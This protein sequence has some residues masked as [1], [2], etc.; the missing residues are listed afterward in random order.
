M[1][2]SNPEKKAVEL[3]SKLGFSGL[4]R[5]GVIY[6]HVMEDPNLSMMAKGIY[7]VISSLQPLNCPGV[8]SLKMFS[9]LTNVGPG[10]FLKYRQELINAGYLTLEFEPP[11][12]NGPRVYI[13][14]NH[15]NS[16]TGSCTDDNGSNSLADMPS[17][18]HGGISCITMVRSDMNLREKAVYAYI[19]SL[20]GKT[21]P[22]PKAVAVVMNKHYC[23]IYDIYGKLKTIDPSLPISRSNKGRPKK[24]K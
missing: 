23:T 24:N 17:V 8:I 16:T 5:E 14:H 1:E 13:L 9:A 6:R 19:K 20:A 15:P 21:A 11:F 18:K 12:N 2:S 10:T 22:N 4:E 3:L 7:A